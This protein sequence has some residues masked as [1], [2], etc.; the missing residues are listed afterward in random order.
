[1]EPKWVLAF[2][3][4]ASLRRL[5][6]QLHDGRRAST[7]SSPCDVYV[8]GCPPR[9]EA[10]LDGLLLLQDKI[11]PRRS[12]ARH[13][14]AARRSGAT[15]LVQLAQEARRSRRRRDRSQHEQKVARAS[16]EGR[17][18]ATRSSRR[19]RSSATTPPSS[20]PA[21][22]RDV[23]AFLRDDPRCDMDMFVDL[24]GVDYPEPRAALRG[25]AAPATRS[26][27]THRLRLKAR[28]G[29]AEGDGAEIDTLVDRVARR[30]LVRARDVRHV[31]RRR[32]A[33]T[34]IC[35]AS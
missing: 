35:A 22:W 2:G 20:T 8:P 16:L 13:R 9:P 30:E 34:R 29:D 21:R 32:S 31:R 17:S 14:E 11:A 5:L 6:R 33:A 3:T 15:T 1:M 4:C 12:H 10:V 7:K 19:T 24:C 27:K 26:R 23:A 25:R 28:V 18:S